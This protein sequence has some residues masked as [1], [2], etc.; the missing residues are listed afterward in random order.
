M[1][2]LRNVALISIAAVAVS[3]CSSTGSGGSDDNSS[4]SLHGYNP[5]FYRDGM[6]LEQAREQGIEGLAVTAEGQTSAK[7]T[8]AAD[9]IN[10]VVDGSTYDFPLQ[11]SEQGSD[12]AYA[13]YTNP[14][15]PS[16]GIVTYDG[17]YA[18]FAA[19]IDDQSGTPPTLIVTGQETE[20][21]PSQQ[22]SYAG[23]WVTANANLDGEFG[24]KVDFDTGNIDY[25]VDG[26][27]DIVGQGS[28][29]LS[30]SPFQGS[31]AFSGA[32]TG[33]GSVSGALFGPQAE[34]IAGT[35]HGTVG[36]EDYQA[37]FHGRQ[38]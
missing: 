25:S 36:G 2:V 33:S 37:V 27:R 19:I 29:K 30:G 21:L 10:V 8:T 26:L 15:D 1:I 14:N 34:E 32:E 16:S 12:Y 9:R 13:L 3:G 23:D 20:Q 28:A 22:A 4:P 35:S 24:A 17:D 18:G 11:E 38:E 31:I 6:T 7:I 5:T